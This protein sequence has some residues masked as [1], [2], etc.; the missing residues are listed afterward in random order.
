MSSELEV[1]S[2][3]E[4]KVDLPADLKV[5]LFYKII[6]AGDVCGYTLFRVVKLKVSTTLEYRNSIWKTT[7]Q[8][9][10]LTGLLL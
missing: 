10:L 8:G 4:L 3:S 2:S 7:W 6:H 5:D 1:D 9:F